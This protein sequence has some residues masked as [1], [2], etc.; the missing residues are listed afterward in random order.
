[1]APILIS[2][3]MGARVELL[4][5]IVLILVLSLVLSLWGIWITVCWIA[6]FLYILVTSKRNKFLNNQIKSYFNFWVKCQEY[7]L[8][9]TDKRPV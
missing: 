9:L 3:R 4:V 8:L 7:F 6:Q 1:L 5:R 2:D